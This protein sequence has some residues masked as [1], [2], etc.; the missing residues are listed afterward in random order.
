[1]HMAAI[2]KGSLSFGLVNI[3]IELRSAVKSTEKLSFRQLDPK[4]L[5]PIRY[6]RVSTADDKVVEYKDL[7]K[8]VKHTGAPLKQYL[9]VVSGKP[10]ESLVANKSPDMNAAK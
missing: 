1:M 6:E 3:P 9:E 10:W 5:K 4:H 8:S 7:K 2:W